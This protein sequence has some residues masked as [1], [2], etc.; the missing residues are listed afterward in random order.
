MPANHA[1]IQIQYF[2]C[3]EI[4]IVWLRREN[5]VRTRA[6]FA[7]HFTQR[8]WL[9]LIVYVR[10]LRCAG[11]MRDRCT[12]VCTYLRVRVRSLSQ[13]ACI[14]VIHNMEEVMACI[15][16]GEL[17]VLWHKQHTHKHW[18]R[19]TLESCMNNVES[20]RSIAEQRGALA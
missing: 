18:R 13:H 19:Q 6:L 5:P 9:N 14:C 7:S 17:A 4:V 20:R 10:I 3:I 12:N 11:D 1:S 15:I 16:Y 8:K 2:A